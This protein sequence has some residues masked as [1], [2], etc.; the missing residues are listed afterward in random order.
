MF[1]ILQFMNDG[2]EKDREKDPADKTG[3]TPEDASYRIIFETRKKRPPQLRKRLRQIGWSVFLA[4]LF[5]CVAAFVFARFTLFFL[6]TCV[7]FHS[8]GEASGQPARVF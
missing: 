7:P 6:R 4:V 2:R 5:G 3:K 8:E 1:V